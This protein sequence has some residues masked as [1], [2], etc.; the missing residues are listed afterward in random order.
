MNRPYGKLEEVVFS[1]MNVTAMYLTLVTCCM[2]NIVVYIY[3]IFT[4]VFHGIIGMSSSTKCDEV[5]RK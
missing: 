2:L 5:R 1:T 4:V 3:L